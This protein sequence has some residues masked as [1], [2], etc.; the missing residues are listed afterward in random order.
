MGPT[1]PP[2]FPG[3]GGFASQ[4]VFPTP[5]PQPYQPAPPANTSTQQG[6]GAG[7]GT[8]DGTGTGPQKKRARVVQTFDK[9]DLPSF[10]DQTNGRKLVH[11]REDAQAY[12]AALGKY[13]PAKDRNGSTI[14]DDNDQAVGNNDALARALIWQP[15]IRLFGYDLWC[16]HY[17]LATGHDDPPFLIPTREIAG[18]NP[19]ESYLAMCAKVSTS[20]CTCMACTRAVAGIN[21]M[22]TTA[23]DNIDTA[24]GNRKTRAQDL[25]SGNLAIGD[26]G[27][28]KKP[29]AGLSRDTQGNKPKVHHNVRLRGV[30]GMG[31]TGRSHGWASQ[32]HA[33]VEATEE[34]VLNFGV[35]CGDPAIRSTIAHLGNIINA[36]SQLMEAMILNP[37]HVSGSALRK[38]HFSLHR[39]AFTY[40]NY[41]TGITHEIP[42]PEVFSKTTL[43][44]A[45]KDHYVTGV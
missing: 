16:Q 9:S 29:R 36:Q 43:A 1:S 34:L 20:A 12:L 8:G 13:Y 2:G 40:L 42:S 26:H 38:D 4:P 23:T 17:A 45:I 24:R 15:G 10:A 28:A 3:W 14:T 25:L 11:S 32:L 7:T 27:S 39:H 44:N 19:E 21:D 33:I 5:R 35:R 6:T 37:G 30:T 31:K 18:C 41:Q 22:L